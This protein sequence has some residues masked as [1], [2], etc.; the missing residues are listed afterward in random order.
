MDS[1]KLMAAGHLSPSPAAIA[2]PAR[3]LANVTIQ[4]SVVEVTSSGGSA[5]YGT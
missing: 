2:S 3:S 5:G 4:I 1:R